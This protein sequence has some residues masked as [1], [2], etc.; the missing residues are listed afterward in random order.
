[1][2]LYIGVLIL[3]MSIVLSSCTKL[4]E[5]PIGV[6]SPNGFFKTK[7]DVEASLYGA[8]GRMASGTSWGGTMIQL[9]QLRSDMVDI[10]NPGTPLR[11]REINS[12]TDDATN[13]MTA[14]IWPIMYSII[15]AA[16]NAILGAETIEGSESDKKALEAEGR[17]VRAYIYYVLVRL[18]GDIPY[19]DSAISDPNSVE[20]ISKTKESDV[21][22]SI[23]S[24]LEYGVENLPYKFAS[25]ARSRATSGTAATILASV[26]LTLENWQAA[27]DNAK[28]VIDHKGDLGYELV[29]DSQTLFD[30]TQQDG[31][32]EHIFAV[33]F[34]GL[35]RHTDNDDTTGPFTTPSEVG[36]WDVQVPSLAVYTTWDP[37]D[38]RRKVSL[39]DE[40]LIDGTLTPYT[41]WGIS[42]PHIAKYNRF[43]GNAQTDNRQSDT[44]YPLYRYAEVLLIAAEA[45]NEISG[46]TEE[47]IGYINEVR[48]RA[49]TWPDHIDTFPE[50]V[51]LSIGSDEFRDVVLEERRL[52]LAFEYKRWFDIK[53]RN[54]GD[55]VFK[56]PNSLEP[57]LNFDSTKHYLLA[58]PQ[59]ELDRNTNLLPQNTGY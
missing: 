29:P 9:L 8:Y 19:I 16:N 43:V 12:F 21:Y 24:D 40:I 26:H 14:E 56:G 6:L 52:E 59:D 33:D 30:A 10:G 20:S 50:D 28:W 5:E 32:S 57:R 35:Q 1:M 37:R 22:N 25:G 46:V 4:E 31:I 48:E 39:D 11:R 47:T 15:G 44:N 49:R 2:K 45:L 36:G 51:S 41:E 34:L 55:E 27:Y 58:L 53:R 54:L 38:Y 3:C 23:I 18:Y 7:A 42:R 13:G 17:V